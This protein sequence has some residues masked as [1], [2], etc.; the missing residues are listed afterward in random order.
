MKNTTRNIGNIIHIFG[1]S[2]A[3]YNFSNLDFF[4]INN[5]QLC[6]TMHKVGRDKINFI[7]YNNYEI[8]END[9]IVYQFGEIDCRCHI[10][11]QLLL[12]RELDEIIETLTTNYINSISENKKQFH[13]LYIIICCVPPPTDKYYYEKING[14][15][16]DNFPLPFIGT[17][18][19]RVIYTK[20]INTILKQ[21]CLENDL[22]FFDYYDSYSDENGLLVPELSDNTVHIKQ[23]EKLLELFKNFIHTN[24]V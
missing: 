15:M 24:F 10:G 19:E 1:D 9:I 8:I 5:Y 17:N 12:N 16:P 18:E 21:K 23:N 11:K 22:L 14:E 13:K 20:K 3:M 6:T 2:H 7:N 4:H